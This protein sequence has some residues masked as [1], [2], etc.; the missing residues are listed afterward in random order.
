MPKPVASTSRPTAR[1]KSPLPSPSMRT[2]PVAREVLHGAGGREGARHGEEDDP[3]PLEYLAQG[4]VL[5]SAIPHLLE[6]QVERERVAN[7]DRHVSS[8]GYGVMRAVL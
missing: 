8:L 1:V 5:R 7:L 4:D 2:L 6:P 3:L